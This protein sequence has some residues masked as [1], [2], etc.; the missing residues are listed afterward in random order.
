MVLLMGILSMWI[1]LSWFL[2]IRNLNFSQDWQDPPSK[3]GAQEHLDS[4]V[5]L[6]DA[7]TQKPIKEL[8]VQGFF[9]S[10]GDVSDSANPSEDVLDAPWAG[11]ETTEIPEKRK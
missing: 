2:L 1:P 11:T 5:A 4:G 6:I 7:A 10:G 8:A 3:L 9:E